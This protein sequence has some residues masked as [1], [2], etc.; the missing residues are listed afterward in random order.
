MSDAEAG[1]RVMWVNV[2]GPFMDSVGNA[3][4][5]EEAARKWASVG[6]KACVRVEYQMGEGLN[7]DEQRN[8]KV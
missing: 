5:T 2:Y 3:Y 7:A 1:K 6:L 4:P 8:R